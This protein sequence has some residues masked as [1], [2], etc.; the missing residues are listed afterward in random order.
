MAVARTWPPSGRCL[1]LDLRAV[2][3]TW[4]ASMWATSLLLGPP[5]G[6]RP[7]RGFRVATRPVTPEGWSSA[8]AVSSP[9]RG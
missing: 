2:S 7:S 5:G 8:K 1:R 3:V 4:K 6:M 9:G